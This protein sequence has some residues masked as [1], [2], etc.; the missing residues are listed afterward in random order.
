MLF[1]ANKSLFWH[2]CCWGCL[3]L[4]RDEVCQHLF[5]KAVSP[6]LRCAS[7]NFRVSI[8]LEKTQHIIKRCKQPIF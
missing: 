4:S 6:Q 8:N 2:V 1:L 5:D 3:L 7:I